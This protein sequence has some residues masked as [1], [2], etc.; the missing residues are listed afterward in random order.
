MP[1]RKNE[2]IWIEA[3]QRWQ[4]NVQQDG[5]RRTFTDTALGKK[6]KAVAE[7]KADKWLEN[8][9]NKD[10]RFYL[11]WNQFLAEV[12]ET[13]STSNYKKHEQMGRLWLLPE[14]RH[15]RL[16]KITSHDWQKVIN[17]AYRK[18]LAKKSLQNIRASISAIWKYAAKGQH[19]LVRPFALTIPKNAPEKG[20]KILQPDS[21]R[22]LFSNDT[23]TKNRKP[24]PCFFIHAWRFQVLTG[25]RPGEVAGL[26]KTDVSHRQLKIKR[27]INN[28]KEETQGKNKNAR[29]IMVLTRRA[30]SVLQ[31]QTAMLKL[32]GIIST[33]LFP[34]EDGD[35]MDPRHSYRLWRSYR[36]QHGITSSLYELRHTMVSVVKS[37][38]PDPLLKMVV[39]HSKDM[40][41]D[42]VY[43]HKVDGNL[44]RA[45]DILD[46]VF[47]G[48]L[49]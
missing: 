31:D 28:F 10:I 27:A 13:T 43:G 22:T 1:Q 16:S 4:V 37:D 40:D 8:R 14:I 38:M 24:T 3:R 11:L 15:K 17:K 46:G 42:G 35:P 30:Q 26:K 45:A 49:E 39:G 29:R 32:H 5:E 23:I 33:W 6:G 19:P 12:K 48:I 7:R 41:T 36:Q 47:D 18:G 9:Q 2:A 44:Q 21:L 25:M 20:R 34:G